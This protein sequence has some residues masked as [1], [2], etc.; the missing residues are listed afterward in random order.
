LAV[1]FFI[2]GIET[3]IPD[4][5]RRVLDLTPPVWYPLILPIAADDT[6]PAIVIKVPM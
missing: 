2:Q 3:L 6:L 1:L 4:S 5:L